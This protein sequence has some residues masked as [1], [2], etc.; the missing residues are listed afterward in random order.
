LLVTSSAASLSRGPWIGT[1]VA[2]L[3]V[4]AA[5]TREAGVRVRRRAIVGAVALTTVLAALLLGSQGIDRIA[6][7]LTTMAGRADASVSNRFVYATTALRIARDRPLTGGG[8]DSFGL[9]YPQYRPAEA[10]NLPVDAIPT[11]VHNGYLHLLAANGLPALLAY[12]ALVLAVLVRLLTQWRSARTAHA[13]LMAAA[14]A[15][16]IA[17]YLV[18]DLTGWEELPLTLTF[19]AVLGL[20][21]ASGRPPSQAPAARRPTRLLA[22]GAAVALALLMAGTAGDTLL[23]L[24]ADR[25]LASARALD[26]R[27]DWRAIEAHLSQAV[28]GSRFHPHVEDAAGVLYLERFAATPDKASYVVAGRL[29]ADAMRQA[30]STPYTLIHRVDLETLA[31]SAGTIG[32]VSREAETVLAALDRLDPGNA[33]VHESVARL[34]L[35]QGHPAEGLTAIRQ[36]MRLRPGHRRYAIWEGDALRALGDRTRAIEAYRRGVALTEPATGEWLVLNRRIILALLETGQREAA[37]S[38]A[39]RLLRRV[40]D[41]STRAALAAADL[42]QP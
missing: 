1:A 10:A 38:A 8:F 35:A 18:Q 2:V 13:R 28:R 27:S 5:A 34:R 36:A 3:I 6:Q 15:G 26:V 7:R 17:G 11:M 23:A 30:P 16:A 19:W 12:C 29:F 9:L 21:V 25:S 42:R 4:M 37:Q 20:A 14:F 40:D 24:G 31:L 33:T 41:P 22:C 32:S 39:A